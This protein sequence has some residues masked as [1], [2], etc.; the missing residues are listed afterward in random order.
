MLDDEVMG[1]LA[2]AEIQQPLKVY[3]YL[4]HGWFSPTNHM[5]Y[6]VTIL[7]AAN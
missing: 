1:V 4:Y 7:Y 3:N 5:C 6:G 2:R